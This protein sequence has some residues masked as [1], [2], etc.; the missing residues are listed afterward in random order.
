MSS[1]FSTI[2]KQGHSFSEEV[3]AVRRCLGINAPVIYKAVSYRSN[4][5]AGRERNHDLHST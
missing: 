5:N 2:L 3:D 4:N 1:V